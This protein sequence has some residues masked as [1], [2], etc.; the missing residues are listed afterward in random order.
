MA[1]N[2][3]VFG[4]VIGALYIAFLIVLHNTMHEARKNQ[5]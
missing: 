3:L 4:L 1:T 5:K 2:D